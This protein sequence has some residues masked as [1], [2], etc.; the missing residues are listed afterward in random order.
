VNAAIVTDVQ[1][2][3]TDPMSGGG[4]AFSNVIGPIPRFPKSTSMTVAGQPEIVPSTF[5]VD[6]DVFGVLGLEAGT[7]G[8]HRF[9]GFG[10]DVGGGEVGVQWLPAL[11]GTFVGR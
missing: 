4:K 6:G 8:Q 5:R 11:R 9:Q 7:I 1:G 10:G 3:L 2:E